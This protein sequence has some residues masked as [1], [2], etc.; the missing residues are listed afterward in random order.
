[1]VIVI[2]A[3][4]VVVKISTGSFLSVLLDIVVSAAATFP[5]SLFCHWFL[6]ENVL[7]FFFLP[8]VVYQI[9]LCWLERPSWAH[10][11]SSKYYLKITM[12][13]SLFYFLVFYKWHTIK[14]KWYLPY[15]LEISFTW[16]AILHNAV[17][18]QHSQLWPHNKGPLSFNFLQHFQHFF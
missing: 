2:R 11:F 18:K 12:Y 8:E 9:I 17:G 14:A 1:M 15:C 7:G 3:R 4:H 5:S 10:Y 16:S 6:N 13:S